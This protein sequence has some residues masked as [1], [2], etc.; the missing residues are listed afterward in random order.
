MK[1]DEAAANSAPG[2]QLRIDSCAMAVRIK[3]F[4]VGGDPN[5]PKVPKGG[6]VCG[7]LCLV[8]HQMS[9]SR[10][11]EECSGMLCYDPAVMEGGE[12]NTLILWV[13]PEA[14]RDVEG[15]WAIL[16]RTSQLEPPEMSE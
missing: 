8:S 16:I 12:D 15:Y 9:A 6:R 5:D 2:L 11:E 14:S 10:C 7:L 1:P 3:R 13:P 4:H